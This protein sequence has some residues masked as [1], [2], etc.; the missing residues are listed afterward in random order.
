MFSVQFH[1]AELAK[2]GFLKLVMN[3]SLPVWGL[4]I[5][6]AYLTL[7]DPGGQVVLNRDEMNQDGF[8]Y[9]CSCYKVSWAS[10]AAA[11]EKIL[12]FVGS[13]SSPCL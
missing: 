1:N 13:H 6:K 3:A 7:T 12:V 2:L 10:P 5:I 4:R 8:A 9:L 11:G